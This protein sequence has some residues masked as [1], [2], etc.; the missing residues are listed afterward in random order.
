[1][2]SEDLS[3]HAPYLERPPLRIAITG[4]SGLVGTQLAAFLTTGGH[5]VLR[6]PRGRI[7]HESLEGLDAVV[8]LAGENIA[9]GR[10]TDERKA[11][12]L[13]S[14][15]GGTKRL[16]EALTVLRTPPAVFLSAVGGRLLRVSRGTKRR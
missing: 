4:S 16:A 8:H 9:A 15:V 7:D 2:I 6:V 12:I 10:W 11:E 13:S 14:R 3:R 5:E 1:V